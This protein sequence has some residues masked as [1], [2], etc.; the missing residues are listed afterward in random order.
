MYL[1]NKHQNYLGLLALLVAML[2]LSACEKNQTTGPW[3]EP[4]TISR[5]GDNSRAHSAM[6]N[7]FDAISVWQQIEYKQ[8]A[9]TGLDANIAHANHNHS[10]YD[11]SSRVKIMA[12]LGRKSATEDFANHIVWDSPTTLATGEWT[13]IATIG[14][15][16]SGV[17]E[18]RENKTPGFVSQPQTAINNTGN[19][20]AVWEA[21]DSVGV[22]K[23]YF[24][25]FDNSTNTWSTP[26]ELDSSHTGAS[27]QPQVVSNSDGSFISVWQ[28]HSESLPFQSTI[29]ASEYNGS[30]WTTASLLSDDG[31]S[32]PVNAH[33][34]SLAASATLGIVVAVWV[35]DN[36]LGGAG[37]DHKSNIY[38]Q[39]YFPSSAWDANA[40]LISTNSNNLS[41]PKV[42]LNTT[43]NGL[44]SWLLW[45]LQDNGDSTFSPLP[46]KIQA[47]TINN[48]GSD[49]ADTSGITTISSDASEYCL[50]ARPSIDDNGDAWVVWQQG[51]SDTIL[52]NQWNNVRSS[53]IWGANLLSGT[54]Q[55]ASQV[56]AN[57]R[58]P[59]QAPELA[60]DSNGLH[61]ITWQQWQDPRSSTGFEIAAKTIA[62]DG[63][64]GSIVSVS[65]TSGNS[66]RLSMSKNLNNQ[67]IV[68][69][70]VD[71]NR[72]Q[73]SQ[74][75]SSAAN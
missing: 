12:S 10:H 19:G 25:L 1:D 7:S 54:W 18:T 23:A 43:G 52:A 5:G 27:S 3:Q 2:A 13:S 26:A 57:S 38:A 16:G 67:I 28:R 73:T 71:N 50:Y 14:E 51:N 42:S 44:V 40:T 20:I 9:D 45:E 37:T 32:N 17:T 53:Q 33:S 70:D 41:E 29:Y 31:V 21:K 22:S 11:V 39:R 65:R 15:T 68:T 59:A 46:S 66:Q 56:S 36:P 60:I 49:W 64:S 34:A 75:D 69:W 8:D 24:S 62:S 61:V 72:I 55:S 48:S 4:Q 58:F 47:R 6:N 35:Q 30:S 74:L 63:S